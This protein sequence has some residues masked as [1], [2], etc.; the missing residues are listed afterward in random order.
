MNTQKIRK[1]LLGLFIVTS[2]F[3]ILAQLISAVSTTGEPDKLQ[4]PVP[5]YEQSDSLLINPDSL[6]NRSEFSNT[7]TNER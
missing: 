1:I 3:L 2:V 5:D 4:S 7:Y 6:W